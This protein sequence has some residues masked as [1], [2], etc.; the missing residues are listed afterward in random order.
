MQRV[1]FF[2]N[3]FASDGYSTHFAGSFTV[4]AE[5]PAMPAGIVFHAFAR[6]KYSANVSAITWL[7]NK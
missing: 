6:L 5:A 7:L 3:D 2:R 4:V 1:L